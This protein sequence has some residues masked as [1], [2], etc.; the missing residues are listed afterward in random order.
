M[1]STYWAVNPFGGDS[2]VGIKTLTVTINKANKWIYDEG[3]YSSD[4]IIRRFSRFMEKLDIP[5]VCY[6]DIGQ[7]SNPHM[8]CILAVNSREAYMR[9]LDSF[10]ELR[11]KFGQEVD[12]TSL[13]SDHDVGRWLTYSDKPRAWHGNFPPDM[14]PTYARYRGMATSFCLS[15]LPDIITES[16]GFED[17]EV[18]VSRPQY[19]HGEKLTI[20]VTQV[21]VDLCGGDKDDRLTFM[22]E[23][24]R[25]G[26]PDMFGAAASLV[27]GNTVESFVRMDR[28]TDPWVIDTVVKEYASN[29]EKAAV[30]LHN[31]L[32]EF[33]KERLYLAAKSAHKV[34]S[35][36]SYIVNGDVIS[37]GVDRTLYGAYLRVL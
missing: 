22:L 9:L 11:K 2:M 5:G 1:A 23:H 29:P 28:L 15:N 26:L 30:V 34:G 7:N 17:K 20:P 25:K 10:T 3:G 36:V 13:D 4:K 33:R 14:K 21:S 19:V 18:D 12:L 35:D 16:V 24:A 6:F 8:H 37:P 32:F 31:Q 27:R